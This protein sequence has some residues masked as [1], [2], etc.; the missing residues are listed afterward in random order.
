MHVTRLV[1][2]LALAICSCSEPLPDRTASPEA[3]FLAARA[4]LQNHDLRAYF[5]ALTEQ[6]VRDDLGNSITICVAGSNPQAVAAGLR[7]SVG[8][9]D[10]LNHYNWPAQAERS[11]DA[12]K[13]AIAKVQ[14]PRNMVAELEANHRKFDVGSTFGWTYLDKMRLSEMTID[15]NTAH[16]V[17]QWDDDDKRPVRFERDAT[18]WRFDPMAGE[19]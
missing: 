1:C 12:Y 11:T 2:V 8:C 7:T 10:I 15:G 18:G 6:A 3:A 16:A 9:R 5:D 19:R 14:D 4:G 17:A 13:A